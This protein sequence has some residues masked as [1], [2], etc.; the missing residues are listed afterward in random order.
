MKIYQIAIN[1]N[2]K[3][4]NINIEKLNIF[5]YMM[6]LLDIFGHILYNIATNLFFYIGG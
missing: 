3:T 4:I 5:K 1:I 2:T 6:N